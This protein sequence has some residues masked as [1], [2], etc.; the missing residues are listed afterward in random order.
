MGK[1][2]GLGQVRANATSLEVRY[3][4][5]YPQPEPSSLCE[6]RG[7]KNLEPEEPYGFAEETEPLP[8]YGNPPPADAVGA[9]PDIYGLRTIYRFESSSQLRHLWTR[10]APIWVAY[11]RSNRHP[12][13]NRI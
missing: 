8:L 7:L 3:L 6:L 13:E 10:V 9:L 12:T 11:A 5:L 1:S 4:G 2:R